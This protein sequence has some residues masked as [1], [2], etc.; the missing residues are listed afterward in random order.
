MFIYDTILIYC[1]SKK[2]HAQSAWKLA[3]QKYSPAVAKR[4]MIVSAS[5]A[6]P[7]KGI[8]VRKSV[9]L[10]GSINS[11]A[12]L[13]RFNDGGTLKTFG[14]RSEIWRSNRVS[15][16]NLPRLPSFLTSHDTYQTR[17]SSCRYSSHVEGTIFVE[18]DT[19]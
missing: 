6:V 1:H 19:F 5:F 13:R 11:A 12:T 3:V 2:R 4:L 17:S 18:T 16:A 7:T 10:L 8:N 14:K 9:I 15:P